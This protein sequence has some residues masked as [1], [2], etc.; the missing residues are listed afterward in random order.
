M[1]K[2]KYTRHRGSNAPGR[3]PSDVAELAEREG[4]SR[5]A[6]WYRLRRATGRP[7]GRPRKSQKQTARTVPARRKVNKG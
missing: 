1:R 4:I 7:A 2:R 3:P 6:A 5:Q